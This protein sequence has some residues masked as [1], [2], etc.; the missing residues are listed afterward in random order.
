MQVKERYF[1]GWRRSQPVPY[2][3]SQ[4]GLQITLLHITRSVRFRRCVDVFS[5]LFCLVG[6]QW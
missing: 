3:F 5:E 1:A 4:M 2:P 6:L